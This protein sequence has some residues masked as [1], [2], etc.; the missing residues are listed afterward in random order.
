M[1]QDADMKLA[2]YLTAND[3][4]PSAFAAQVGVPAS[5]I[6]RLLKGE[7]PSTGLE[8]LAKIAAATNGKVM[9]NDFLETYEMERGK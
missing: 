5:T 9:P 1:R 8:L 3:I 4:R 6:I 7:R 2:D